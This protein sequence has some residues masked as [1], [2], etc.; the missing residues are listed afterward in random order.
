MVIM[1]PIVEVSINSGNSPLMTEPSL[2]V[3]ES[4]AAA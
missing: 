2:S 4:V 3:K 1:A